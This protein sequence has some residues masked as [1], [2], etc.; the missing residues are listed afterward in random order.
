MAEK[1]EKCWVILND[2]EHTTVKPAVIHN[3][4]PETSKTQ[5][6]FLQP[7]GEFIVRELDDHLVWFDEHDA[8]EEA[9]QRLRDVEEDL[10]V[11]LEEIGERITD[12]D[13]TLN[14]LESR[15]SE[16]SL[17]VPSDTPDYR[18][19]F[20][21]GDLAWAA[22]PAGVFCVQIHKLHL[23][24]SASVKFWDNEQN[25][26]LFELPT[27]QLFCNRDRALDYQGFRA[28]AKDAREEKK[29]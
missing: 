26:A 25:K 28:P 6:E 8:W 23:D 12:V 5:V 2:L 18:G 27:N 29:H 4:L 11:R 22:L 16:G 13:C 24:W 19:Y 7:N 21:P 14:E 15:E 10:Q 3:D 9:R 17:D 20:I 1:G